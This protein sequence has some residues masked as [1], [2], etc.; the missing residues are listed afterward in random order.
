MSLRR[1]AGGEA[2]RFL[3]VRGAALLALLAL[4][5]SATL[6]A[7][8]VSAHRRSRDL[9]LHDRVD[10]WADFQAFAD[11]TRERREQS[12]AFFRIAYWLPPDDH[13]LMAA[14]LYNGLPYY[15]VGYTPAKLFGL[16]T[17][18]AHP[19]LLQQLSVRYVV[20]VS[21][22]TLDPKTIPLAARFGDIWVYELPSWQS[23][24]YR[25]E[26]AG[27]VEEL[28][29]GSRRIALR[30]AGVA[31]GARLVLHV[32][33]HPRWE[34]RLDGSPVPIERVPS[35]EPAGKPILIAVPAR[36]GTLEL[37]WRARAVDWAGSGLSALGLLG[38][39]LLGTRG[40]R[41]R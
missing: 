17:D 28:A 16:I 33:D 27:A 4:A 22:D 39:L 38:L 8:L 34:A 12:A 10:W 14:P 13:H 32:A 6:G 31:P 41:P 24:R 25:L 40:R 37:R 30:L 35:A 9:P 29:F 5:V 7:D 2:A 20:T 11:W 26:G 21:A 3:R 36:D 15:K 1:E 18:S 19:Q 23:R